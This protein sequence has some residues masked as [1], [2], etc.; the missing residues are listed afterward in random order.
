MPV[1]TPS[2]IQYNPKHHGRNSRI[3]KKR[4]FTQDGSKSNQVGIKSVHAVACRGVV[5]L[6][7]LFASNE[8]HDFVLSFSRN[9]QNNVKIIHFIVLECSYI[10]AREND[11]DTLPIRV[12]CDVEVHVVL[13]VV[14]QP[15]HERRTRRDTIRVETRGVR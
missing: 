7:R 6:A 2:T 1:P 15:R 5:V 13:E 14:V 9:L 10:M 11:A 4:L 12:G 3:S 8:I